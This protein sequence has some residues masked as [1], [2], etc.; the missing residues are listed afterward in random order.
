MSKSKRP[1]IVTTSNRGVFF[2]YLQGD[3][4]PESVR[5]TD[6]RNCVYWDAS[7]RG[8]VGLAESGPNARCKIGPAAPEM[9]LYGITSV[10]QCTD[11]AAEMWESAPWA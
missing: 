9:T 7:V 8:F 11:T 4:S 1:V 2:G 10:V 6:A 3:P 5:L